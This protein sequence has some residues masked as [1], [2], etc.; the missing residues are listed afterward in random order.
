MA[1]RTLRL[2][3]RGDWRHAPEN[4]LAA[5]A[6][7]LALP[8]C[9][10]L[11]FDVRLSADGVLVTCH[12][13]TLQRTHGRPDRV[14]ALSADAC[15]ALGI[16]SLAD[17]LRLAGRRSFLDVE[18][19]GDPGPTIVE[20]LAAGRG[21][22]LAGAV[23]SS[24]EPVALERVA[25]LA[26][27]WPRWLNSQTLT[28]V[29]IATALGLG[30]RGIAVE[31]RALDARSVAR[32]QAAGLEVAA[33]TVRRRSTFDRLARLGVVAVCVEAGALDG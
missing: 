28:D 18:L 10:G 7:A 3:H 13:A 29:D 12:D 33:W 22:D 30:C 11:E 17:V 31:W 25:H 1:T 26:P 9:D 32:A 6:A 2:A 24:F 19:K 23:V 14:D 8:A 5:F 15:E 21:P 4:S 27:S 16:P 20:V